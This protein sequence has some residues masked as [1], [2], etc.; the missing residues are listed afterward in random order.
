MKESYI[1]D[2]ASHNGHESC[3]D[4]R[5]VTREALTVVCTGWV[6]SPEKKMVWSA[7]AVKR[8]GRQYRIHH[9]LRDVFELCVVVDPIMYRNSLHGNW[10]ILCLTK[11]GPHRE[12]ARN[13]PMMHKHRKSDVSVVPK[14]SLNEISN[15]LWRRGWREGR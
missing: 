1:E 10:E 9:Y 11:N 6:L 12:S 14:K 5:K 2:L 4:N 15:N 8:A 7:D 13:K 3:M